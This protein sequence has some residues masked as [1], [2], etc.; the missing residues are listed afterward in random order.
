MSELP[1][2][3]ERLVVRRFAAGDV[4]AFAA[5]RSDPEVSR[6]QSWDAPVSEVDA[7]RLVANFAAAEEAAPGWFQ[8]AVELAGE[9]IGD[10]GIGLHDNGMQAEV[11]FTLAR[12]YQGQGYATEA[13]RCVLDRVFDA[14]VHRVSADCDARNTASAKLLERLGF[15]REGRR[16]QHTWANGEWTDDLLFGLLATD[17]PSPV[18][19]I[20]ACRPNVLV[21]DLSTSLRFYRDLLGFGV[22]WRWSDPSGRFLAE[23]DPD[24]PG[25][26]LVVREGAHL[27]LTQ[28][29]DA[30]P[31]RLHLDVNTTT[32]V[33]DLFAEWHGR[34]ATIAEPPSV[35]PWGMYEM[36]LHDPDGTVLRVSAHP[37]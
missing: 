16:V 1:V 21:R 26:A 4:A 2:R 6:Y 5:Y 25:T 34:G 12:P 29:A 23:D 11:G 28:V 18:P 32:Q 14:G 36:R 8:Y 19:A 37:A 10:V 31:T 13:V 7:G 27:I 20:Y 22:G 33:D 24:E 15:R 17:W 9:L 30:H 3:T 35:R